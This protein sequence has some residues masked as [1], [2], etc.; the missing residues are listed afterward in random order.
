MNGSAASQSAGSSLEGM[1]ERQGDCQN[2]GAC[3]R[4]LHVG[5]ENFVLCSIAVAAL[6]CWK[7]SRRRRRE[8]VHVSLESQQEK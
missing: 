2:G 3:N 1:G 8:E 5:R 7:E 4:E 6:M